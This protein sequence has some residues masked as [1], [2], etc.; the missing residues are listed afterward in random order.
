MKNETDSIKN[1]NTNFNSMFN[2]Y[3]LNSIG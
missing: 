3:F 1:N 2:L